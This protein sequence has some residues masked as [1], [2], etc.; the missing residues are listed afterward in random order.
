[1][2]IADRKMGDWQM[3]ETLVTT[4]GSNQNLVS[5]LS[6]YGIQRLGFVSSIDLVLDGLAMI[7]KLRSGR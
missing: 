5:Y 3:R 7:I 4:T 2:H 6:P 1:M